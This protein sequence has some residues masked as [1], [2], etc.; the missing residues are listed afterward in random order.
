M[1]NILK[2]MVALGQSS[3]GDE[4]E[5]EDQDLE[6]VMFSDELILHSPIEEW[7]VVDALICFF[8]EGFPLKKAESYVSLRRPFLVNDVHAQH[9][10]L[11][12]RKVYAILKEHG[13]PV[14]PHIIVNRTLMP[15]QRA[16][17]QCN[18]SLFDEE[19]EKD[20]SHRQSMNDILHDGGDKVNQREEGFCEYERRV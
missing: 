13:I 6:I 10:L 11:D 19:N 2:K 18:A 8:S 20:M 12:R 14:P 4:E 3:S 17:L 9:I 1:Q 16:M 7:P 15:V 5:E